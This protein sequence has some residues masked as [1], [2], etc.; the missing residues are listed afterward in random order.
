VV[1]DDVPLPARL[2]SKP[3]TKIDVDVH[4]QLIE[5]ELMLNFKMQSIIFN[6]ATFSLLIFISI[7]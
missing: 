3:S 7:Q 4:P 1:I 2:S 6:V 5:T